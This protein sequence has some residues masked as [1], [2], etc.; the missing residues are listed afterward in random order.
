MSRTTK[1]RAPALIVPIGDS[2][3]TS[4][5][6]DEVLRETDKAY[7]VKIADEE[8]WIPKSMCRLYHKNKKIHGPEWL[9]YQKGL[10]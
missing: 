4:I 6:F 7:H 2:T 8:H 10:I 9:F 1:G 5:D 3:E